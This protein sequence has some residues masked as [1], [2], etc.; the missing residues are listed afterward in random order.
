MSTGTLALL[1]FSHRTFAYSETLSYCLWQRQHKDS[2]AFA[3]CYIDTEVGIVTT[4]WIWPEFLAFY[5]CRFFSFYKKVCV[6]YKS[7][8]V[9]VFPAHRDTYCHG[10]VVGSALK[11]N[12]GWFQITSNNNYLLAFPEQQRQTEKFWCLYKRVYRQAKEI[13]FLLL[14]NAWHYWNLSSYMLYQFSLFPSGRCIC[15]GY[16]MLLLYGSW[17][18]RR[19][20]LPV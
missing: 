3:F 14:D 4:E 16:P 20:W 17:L 7:S 2:K 12:L 10:L 19:L 1:E 13:S 9:H 6:H 15:W 11:Q 5:A 18:W 8:Q